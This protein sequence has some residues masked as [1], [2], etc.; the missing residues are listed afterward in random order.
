M[1]KYLTEVVTCIQGEKVAH[2]CFV[3]EGHIEVNFYIWEF[4]HDIKCKVEV[5]CFLVNSERKV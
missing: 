3:L 1:G 5:G 2:I 4:F